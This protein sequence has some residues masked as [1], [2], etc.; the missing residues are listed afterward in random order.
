[1]I[2][3]GAKHP[4]LQIPKGHV[5]GKAASVD[6]SVVV[7]VPIAAVDEHV[8]SPVASHIR[9]RNGLAVEQKV[10]DCPGITLPAGMLHQA[11][12][13]ESPSAR[14]T[15]QAIA[16]KL[17]TSRAVINRQVQGIENLG[18]R[19][20]GEI[21]WAIGWEPYFEARRIPDGQNQISHPVGN[22]F[23]TADGG[24][25]N[26]RASALDAPKQIAQGLILRRK[27]FP[28]LQTRHMR[29][30]NYWKQTR[31]ENHFNRQRTHNLAFPS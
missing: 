13:P 9:E 24:K 10:R 6:L 15:Q 11:P 17:G 28:A 7:T 5:I 31:N 29:S 4:G 25:E 14:L 16:E 21:L 20:I 1:M 27:L 30:R 26:R 3:H 8:G 22:A 12:A 18:A 19:R 23:A 2:A